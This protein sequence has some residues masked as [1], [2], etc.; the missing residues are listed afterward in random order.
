MTLLARYVFFAGGRQELRKSSRHIGLTLALI[1]TGTVTT[2]AQE[3]PANEIA[4]RTSPQNTR[5]SSRPTSPSP[6][7]GEAVSSEPESP[8]LAIAKELRA[9]VKAVESMRDQQQ[10]QVAVSFLQV[11]Q[12]RL[13]TLEQQMTTTR[14]QLTQLKLRQEQNQARTGNI[15]N[16]LIGRTILDQSE[17][18]RII[19]AEIQVEDARLQK[20]IL[21]TEQQLL[22]LQ[23]EY[24]QMKFETQQ[25]RDQI[26]NYLR[27]T[28]TTNE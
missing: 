26:W 25:I 7:P 14:T 15:R 24:D 4:T 28:P 11:Q 12:S 1:L 6:Q 5:P 20:E 9:L 22:L 21:A 10:A 16:E 27:A 23:Q 13:S 17:G 2:L 3:R 8:E 19:R 18:E